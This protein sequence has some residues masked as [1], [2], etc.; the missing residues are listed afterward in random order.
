MLLLLLSPFIEAPLAVLSAGETPPPLTAG[1]VA[2]EGDLG[3]TTSLPEQ[4]FS[5]LELLR[6][7]VTEALRVE[8]MS[9]PTLP[10]GLGLLLPAVA[11][12]SSALLL[13]LLERL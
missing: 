12:A 6:E 3:P 5:G 13:L 1:M 8:L 10:R 11:A 4:E 7:E 2:V 9:P